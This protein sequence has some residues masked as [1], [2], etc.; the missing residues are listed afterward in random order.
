MARLHIQKHHLFT[1]ES[2]HAELGGYNAMEGVSR[3]SI[4]T[5]LWRG[6]RGLGDRSI[7]QIGSNQAYTRRR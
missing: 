1:K 2:F 7:E 3:K 6:R 5:N 4:T